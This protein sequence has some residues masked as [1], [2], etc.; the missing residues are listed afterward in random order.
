[1]LWLAFVED[2]D[3]AEEDRRR[4]R[5]RIHLHLFVPYDQA[6]ARIDA[7][8]SAGGRIVT[9]KLPGR[10]TLADPEGNELDIVTPS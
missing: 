5:N 1:M 2:P 8:V 4:Q 9:D 6:Q 3:A 10:W 7:A